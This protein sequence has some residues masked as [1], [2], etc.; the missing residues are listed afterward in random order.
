MRSSIV[1]KLFMLTTG[2]CLVVIASIFIG[3]TVFFEQFYVHQKVEKVKG[4]LQSYRQ[5]EWLRVGDARGAMMKEQAFY[6]ETNAW[7][8][9]LDDKGNLK[10]T[11][12]YEMEVRLERS[13]ALEGES[14]TIPLYAVM[15]VE[16]ANVDSPLFPDMLARGGQRIAIEGVIIQDRLYPQRIGRNASNL[17]EENRLENEQLVRKE[18]EVVPR[19]DSPAE[20]HEQY[21]NVLV[22][23]TITRLRL[24]QG[25]QASR[26]TNRLFLERVKAFQADL[27]YGGDADR[28]SAVTDYT[29]NDI[30]YKIFV[31]RVADETGQ[32]AYLFAM[33][34]LQP[35]HEAAE[36][37][38]HYY[39]YVVAGTLLLVLLAS[40]Y[41]SRTIAAP[42]LRMNA[43]TQRMA[44]LDFSER[45]PVKTEDEFGNLSRNIN[46]LSDLLNA[47]I[48]RL[49]QDIEK[50]RRLEQT[51]KQFIAGVSHELKTPLSVMES[52]LYILQDKADSPKRDY[53][54][55]AMKDEVK[56]MNALVGDMLEL[57]RYESGTYQLKTEPFRIDEVLA[58]ICAKLAPDIADKQL[59]L[60]TRITPAEVVANPHLLEQVIVNFMTNA[61]RYT[62]EQHAIM[63]AAAAGED[64]VQVSVENKGVQIPPEQL[65]K[66]WER[67]YRGEHSRHR[68]TG[69][70]GLGLAI[71]RQILELHGASYGVRN[72]EDGVLFYFELKKKANM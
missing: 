69:G 55:A 46:R 23:G 35:V 14:I 15:N 28:A 43:M 60:H 70:T 67:F 42:L 20:Y 61:I 64:T 58:R 24:P 7:I 44:R 13:A 65:A 62:P 36:I 41:F 10:Y 8:A 18:Y 1:L 54:F 49:E 37:M 50:E 40:F 11:D 17:R 72:T 27:L 39:G 29:E 22:Y 66:I 48:V 59:R 63:V 56:K 68:S 21:P 38:Q 57:A 31:E 9:L 53:Y 32:P 6:Q 51:R 2:L 47:H 71:S 4:A 30:D 19:F 33:T 26:Y 25:E 52:V 3:Q 5:D 16:R 45:L 34:S 12:D